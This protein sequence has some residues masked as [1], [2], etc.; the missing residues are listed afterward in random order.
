[1]D[2]ILVYPV[3]V[4]F[5]GLGF[6]LLILCVVIA[7]TT[8]ISFRLAKQ[9]PPGSGTLFTVAFL[10]VLLGVLAILAL[11]TIKTVP[12]IFAS[13]LGM[14]ILSGLFLQ[15][16]LIKAGWRHSLRTW[17]IA[18]ALQLVIVP[19]AS[20]VLVMGLVSLL[21]LLYPPQY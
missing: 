21:L 5:L 15:K 13:G 14:I 16:W 1:M 6:V 19:V 9:Q 10:Q 8:R 18:A 11:K 7:W 3:L 12:V 2:R 17:G 4:M 20:L